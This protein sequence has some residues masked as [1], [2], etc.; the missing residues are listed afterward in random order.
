[1]M[2]NFGGA[3]H[4]H[5]TVLLCRQFCWIQEGE[6]EAEEAET[7][8]GGGEFVGL[9]VGCAAHKSETPLCLVH[10]SHGP[11]FSKNQGGMTAELMLS[12][13][14]KHPYTCPPHSLQMKIKNDMNKH[15]LE[16]E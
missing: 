13:K 15:S 2:L 1:M 7:S 12:R 10:S 8:G 4:T 16:A 6:E 11:L 5:N 3:D 14:I 9:I